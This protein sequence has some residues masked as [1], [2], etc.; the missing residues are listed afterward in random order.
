MFIYS[1]GR[2]EV[3]NRRIFH[4][5]RAISYPQYCS[6]RHQSLHSLRWKQPN[7]GKKKRTNTSDES[8]FSFSITPFPLLQM[9]L[10]VD[11]NIRNTFIKSAVLSKRLPCDIL[12][13]TKHTSYTNT[14][15]SLHHCSYI[16]LKPTKAADGY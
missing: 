3:K 15:I 12:M 13:I 16:Q 5:L 2:K 4:L 14:K 6:D 9:P 7:T 10:P 1:K 11:T 8:F